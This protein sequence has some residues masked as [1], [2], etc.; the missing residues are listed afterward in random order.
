[1]QI[2][3]KVEDIIFNFWFNLINIPLLPVLQA[4]FMPVKEEGNI[5]FLDRM[6]NR[7]E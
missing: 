2:T 3:I 4:R 5:L 6:T 7:Q 1:M